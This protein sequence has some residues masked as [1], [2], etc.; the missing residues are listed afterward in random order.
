M[1]FSKTRYL[2]S[3]F[4]YQRLSKVNISKDENYL[5][6]MDNFGEEWLGK[7]FEDRGESLR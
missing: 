5:T 3:E 2:L 6:N 7:A 4:L 1:E